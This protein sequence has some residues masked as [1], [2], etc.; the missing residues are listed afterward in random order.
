MEATM[1][2]VVIASGKRSNTEPGEWDARVDLAACYRLVALYGMDDIVYTHISA[3]V[4]ESEDHFLIN[5]FGT[6]FEEI[7]ASMLARVDID[8]KVISPEG[9]HVNEAGFTIHSAIHAARPDV[10]CVIHTHTRA[11][12]ALSSLRQGLLPLCQKSM[13]FQNRLAY[14]GFEG[15][16]FDLTERERLVADLGQHKAMVLRN[17][18]LV[19][20]GRD[21]AEAFSLM[22]QLDLAC[23]VQMDVLAANAAYDLP[24]EEIAEKAAHQLE[25][26]PLTPRD[27]EWPG[28]LRKLDRLDP[29][30]R[31]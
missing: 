29:S 8:G 19:T 10:N 14:H 24:P 27:L 20:C 11:G 7:T 5:C 17:H 22:Y 31:N 21:C 18:G 23:Q 3:R 30:F 16:A 26:Y 4:P 12:M 13:L 6:M 28:L 9:A 25:S 15:I 1:P 2:A